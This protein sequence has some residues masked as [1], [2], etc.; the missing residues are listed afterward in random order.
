MA[1]EFSVSVEGTTISVTITVAA[2]SG[3]NVGEA[4]VQVLNN[5][6]GA[7][8]GSS[9]D[10]TSPDGLSRTLTFDTSAAPGGYT[11]VSAC[12]GEVGL[13]TVTTVEVSVSTLA[14][15]RARA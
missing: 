2:G 8:V 3:Y 13:S 6:T 7:V 9:T 1:A 4:N 5:T 10:D 14:P 12:G 15:A 11:V